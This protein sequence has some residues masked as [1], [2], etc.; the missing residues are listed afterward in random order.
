MPSEQIVLFGAGTI[1]T[2]IA[3]QLIAK[4]TQ[5]AAIADNDPDKWLTRVEGVS[6]RSPEY[7]KEAYPEAVWIPTVLRTPYKQEI[8]EHIVRLGV[9]C[10][11]V[12]GYLP[13]HNKPFEE[14]EKVLAVVTEE[15]SREELW[16]QCEFR[17][18]GGPE[19]RMHD[20]R[21]VYFE[22]FIWQRSDEHYVDCGAADGDTVKEFQSRWEKYRFITAFEPDPENFRKLEREYRDRA[23]CFQYAIGDHVGS[24][25]FAATGDQTSHIAE[26]GIK[27]PLWSLDKWHF[28]APPTFIKMDI[29]GAELEALWGAREIIRKHSPVLAICA[30]H[31]PDHLWQIPLLIHALNP[32]YELRLRR[33]LEATWELIWYAV[34]KE[35]LIGS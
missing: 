15:E 29:E 34:P 12:H 33:Y 25:R 18:H 35:R 32:N 4:G 22:S 2:L 28:R 23:S 3:R 19:R 14:I 26:D 31:E 10:G 1:G 16:N 7:C 5:P 20:I 13:S 11:S 9:V 17:K 6:V 24:V 30:Y 27:V 21:D 8:L